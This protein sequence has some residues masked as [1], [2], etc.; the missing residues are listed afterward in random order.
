MTCSV[1]GCERPAKTKGWCHMHYSRWRRHGDLDLHY[2]HHTVQHGTVN[3]YANFG[4]RCDLCKSAMAEYQK[5]RREVPCVE[6]GRPRW[7]RA[8]GTGL[9]E[10]CWIEQARR[11]ITHGTQSGYKKGCRCDECRAVSNAA[12]SRHRLANIEASRAYDREYKR[13]RYATKKSEGA[14]K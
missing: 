11:P 2:P 7:S 6:C 9:C 3:E 14:P 5:E 13:R 10:E 8:N 1:E 12:R 4:C